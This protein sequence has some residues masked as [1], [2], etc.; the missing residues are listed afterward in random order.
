[1]ALLELDQVSHSEFL[2]LSAWT[3]ALTPLQLDS[4]TCELG[5]ATGMPVSGRAVHERIVPVPL[6]MIR[7]STGGSGDEFLDHQNNN[8]VFLEKSFKV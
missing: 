5:V 6:G 3:D 2:T 4:L 1:M 8:S 7:P